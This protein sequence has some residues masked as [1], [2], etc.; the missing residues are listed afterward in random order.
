MLGAMSRASGNEPMPSFSPEQFPHLHA[1]NTANELDE[2][3]IF[4]ATL[5]AF[6]NAF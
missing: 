6:L 5:K 3:A 2:T 4:V 1:A